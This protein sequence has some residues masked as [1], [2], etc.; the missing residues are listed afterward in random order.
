MGL[1]NGLWLVGALAA[2]CGDDVT[3]SGSASTGMAETG[4]GGGASSGGETQRPTTSEAGGTVGELGSAGTSMSQSIPMRPSLRITPRAHN[5]PAWP[6]APPLS[7]P[8]AATSRLGRPVAG[9][10]NPPDTAAP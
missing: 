7:M 2:G 10:P 9:T 3:G 8:R 6:L 5:A 4:S 1:R